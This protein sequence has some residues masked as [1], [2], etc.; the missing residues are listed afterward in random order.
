VTS[1]T[2]RQAVRSN[3]AQRGMSKRVPLCEK[4]PLRRRPAL[5]LL[6]S[7]PRP[8][9]RRPV[10]DPLAARRVAVNQIENT[11]SISASVIRNESRPGATEPGRDVVSD[12]AAE[13]T[14][15]CCEGGTSA[16]RRSPPGCPASHVAPKSPSEGR[17]HMLATGLGG[18]MVPP[19]RPWLSAPAQARYDELAATVPDLDGAGRLARIVEVVETQQA[20]VDDRCLNLNAATNLPNPHASR[21][22]ASTLGSRPSLG[23]PGR[24]V[25][26]RP[27]PERGAGSTR[28]GAVP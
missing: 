5:L 16:G 6:A 23:H 28:G 20:W 13:Q 7:P 2:T 4:G 10:P 18:R 12:T 9:V 8:R 21:V 27:R 1:K 26:D 17:M 22:L 15:H 24:Q 3:D 14:G 19:R 25:R 11:R